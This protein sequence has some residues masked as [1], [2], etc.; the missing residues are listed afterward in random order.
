MNVY[1]DCLRHIEPAALSVPDVQPG[2]ASSVVKQVPQLFIVDFKQL[3][4]D[5]ILTLQ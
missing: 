1:L 5:L 4:L 2:M 3:H